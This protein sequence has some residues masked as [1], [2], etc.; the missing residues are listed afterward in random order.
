MDYLLNYFG[1][2]ICGIAGIGGK[3]ANGNGNGDLWNFMLQF[4]DIYWWINGW[5]YHTDNNTDT[6]PC[7]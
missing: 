7:S 5:L 6:T 2:F 3:Y 4:L 1:I